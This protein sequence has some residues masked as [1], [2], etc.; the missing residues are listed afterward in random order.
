MAID[1]PFDPDGTIRTAEVGMS[2]VDPTVY[3]TD[4]YSL[5]GQG[6]LVECQVKPGGWPSS[7]IKQRQQK[8]R[9][10]YPSDPQLIVGLRQAG[11]RQ[12]R[13]Y[14]GKPRAINWLFAV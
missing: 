8:S 7:L 3:D 9:P 10:L 5:A 1:E 2:P 13:E 11:C 12:C 4:N 14:Y 6:E